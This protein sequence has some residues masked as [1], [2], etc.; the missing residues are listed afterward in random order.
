MIP[1]KLVRVLADKDL[2]ENWSKTPA[3]DMTRDVMKKVLFESDEYLAVSVPSVLVP[4]ERNLVINPLHV[5]YADVLKTIKSLGR[6]IG[7]NRNL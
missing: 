1:D 4:E 2:P 3:T 5:D 6:H 7:P